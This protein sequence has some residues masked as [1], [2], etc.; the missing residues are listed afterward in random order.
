MDIYYK[1]QDI[2]HPLNR[3][4]F[5]EKNQGKIR[6]EQMMTADFVG[7][8][9]NIKNADTKEDRDVMIRNA[10]AG[11]HKRFA[12]ELTKIMGA[13]T[14]RE[15]NRE[16]DSLLVLMNEYAAIMASLRRA[17]TQEEVSRII[18]NCLEL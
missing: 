12:N 2:F 11:R 5:T 8:L 10:I 17:G 3:D 18:Q 9:N 13:E 6:F 4:A 16:V 7:T 15:G 14:R 1:F